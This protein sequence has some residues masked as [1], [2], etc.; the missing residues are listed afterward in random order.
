MPFHVSSSSRPLWAEATR[1]SRLWSL[2]VAAS[3]LLVCIA[4]ADKAPTAKLSLTTAFAEEQASALRAVEAGEPEAVRRVA[5]AATERLDADPHDAEAR[6][7]LGMTQLLQAEAAL[8]RNDLNQAMELYLQGRAT[9]VQAVEQAPDDLAIRATRAQFLRRVADRVPAHMRAHPLREAASDFSAVM[10]QLDGRLDEL[11][12]DDRGRL[13]IGVADV[14]SRL[15]RPDRAREYSQWVVENLPE[16]PYAEQAERLLREAEAQLAG[17]SLVLTENDRIRG[18]AILWSEIRYNFAHFES[19]PEVDWEKVFAEYLPQVREADTLAAYYHVL[20]RCVAQ[21]RDGHTGV[22]LHPARL[23]HVQP[24]VRIEPI[25]GQ[26][27]VTAVGESVEGIGLGDALTH[28]DGD[29]VQQVLERRY[30][31]IP[32][33]TPQGR[34]RRACAALLEGPSD[35]PVVVSLV[36]LDGAKRDVTLSRDGYQPYP[37]IDWSRARKSVPD[38]LTY[39]RLPHFATPEIVEQFDARFEEI[40][41][42][43]GLILDLRDNGGGNATF[44]NRI[45]A[46]LIDEPI[47]GLLGGTVEHL[48]ARYAHTGKI[49]WRDSGRGRFR[50]RTGRATRARSL[51]SPTRAPSALQKGSSPCCTARSARRWSASRQWAR[52]ARFC[53]LSC[54]RASG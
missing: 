16:T 20:Q 41:Q 44:G 46:R 24:S 54:R 2:A 3:L 18:L 38:N 22:S 36:S 28:V 42:A 12:I 23:G 8:N 39:V 47:P 9:T 5:D 26:A 45:I 29:P 48:G 37:R 21:L 35:E 50:R 31:V 52:R 19:V 11:S 6:L 25:E 17:G 30:D 40:L 10:R 34:D 15:H 32:D 14:M 1:A 4:A 53:S 43:N 33:F 7:W 13:M 51:C 27:I 49:G